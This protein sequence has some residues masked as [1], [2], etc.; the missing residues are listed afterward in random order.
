[1]QP[2]VEMQPKFLQEVGQN[3][4][5]ASTSH[6]LNPEPMKAAEEGEQP[7]QPKLLMNPLS[8]DEVS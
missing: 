7:K 3:Q 8:V 5:E 6:T 2:A 4:T 1:M